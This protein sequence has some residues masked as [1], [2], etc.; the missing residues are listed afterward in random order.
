MDD[1]QLGQ[2]AYEAYRDR[3][4]GRSLA[5]GEPLPAWPQLS[6]DIREAWQAAALAVVDRAVHIGQDAADVH[7][8]DRREPLDTGP[9][10][11]TAA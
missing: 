10:A 5:S 8:G 11:P 1:K 9:G 4:D 7:A 3:A 2:T 6:P